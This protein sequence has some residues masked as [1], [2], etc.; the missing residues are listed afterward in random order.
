MTKYPTP[1]VPAGKSGYYVTLQFSHVNNGKQFKRS[2]KTSDKREATR[3]VKSLVDEFRSGGFVAPTKRAEMTK[4]GELVAMYREGV[5]LGLIDISTKASNSVVNTLYRLLNATFTKEVLG[6]RQPVSEANRAK[7]DKMRLD[8]A[9]AEPLSDNYSLVS[10]ADAMDGMVES[11]DPTAYHLRLEKR[12]RGINDQLIRVKAL[13]G[14]NAS[15]YYTKHHSFDPKEVAQIKAFK[16]EGDKHDSKKIEK[17]PFK[18]PSQALYDR[19]IAWINS[20]KADMP[21]EWITLT[22]CIS[23]GCRGMEVYNCLKTF[24]KA[25]A[26]NPE[27]TWLC[28]PKHACKT[29]DRRIPMSTALVQEIIAISEAPKPGFR[30]RKVRDGMY[31]IGGRQV[32]ERCRDLLAAEFGDELQND[33]DDGRLHTLR[34]IYG[35]KVLSRTRDIAYVSRLLGHKNIQTTMDVYVDHDS[36]V[37]PTVIADIMQ[38]SVSVVSKVA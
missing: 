29:N 7:L 5:K 36:T 25:D 28:L 38:P 26:E 16:D 23:A 35:S 10:I 30:Q 11:D 19:L 9:F 2:L 13:F 27:I 3:R 12:K 8:D 4:V 6:E 21:Q 37:E 17:T 1:Y 31:L 20:L 18:A 22:M 15:A 32:L 24:F 33:D 34:K 14:K